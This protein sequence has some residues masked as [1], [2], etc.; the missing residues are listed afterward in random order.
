MVAGNYPSEEVQKVFST[1]KFNK[2]FLAH[3]NCETSTAPSGTVTGSFEI[4]FNGLQKGFSASLRINFNI[5]LTELQNK[6]NERKKDD[7][8]IMNV[9]DVMTNLDEFSITIGRR[10]LQFT[11][12]LCSLKGEEDDYIGMADFYIRKRG[13]IIGEHYGI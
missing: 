12:Y 3:C 7:P 13:A 9:P 1:L 4:V 6:I 8:S 2:N 11:D 10:F 5:D